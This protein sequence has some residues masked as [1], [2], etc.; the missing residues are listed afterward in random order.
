MDSIIGVNIIIPLYNGIEFLHE[1]INSV[2]A[3][4][5]KYWK[6]IVGINGHSK[7]SNVFQTALKYQ[8]N[9]EDK[10]QSIVVKHY[11]TKGKSETCNE[12]LKDCEYDAICML[13]VDD[14]W[15]PEKLGKQINVWRSN[16]FAVVGTFCSYFGD[17]TGTPALPSYIVNNDCI[18][19]VNPIINS[20]AM[21]HKKD[22]HWTDEFGPEDYDMWLRLAYE[23]KFFFNIPEVL[24]FHRI[25]AASAF[26]NTNSSQVPRLLDH[27]RQKFSSKK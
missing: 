1:S 10:F 5:Y 2:K 12:M 6:V 4:T 19:N 22:A 9:P 18:F 25:H 13:D 17:R 23:G 27:W 8:Q 24:V 26:N 7:D 16:L 20:S 14:A 15:K 11:P 3:Q 21:F